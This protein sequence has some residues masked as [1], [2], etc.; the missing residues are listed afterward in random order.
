MYL[1]A[2]IYHGARVK[3]GISEAKK[4]GAE[5]KCFFGSQNAKK[6]NGEQE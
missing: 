4:S 6:F 5:V 2:L 3:C 1:L